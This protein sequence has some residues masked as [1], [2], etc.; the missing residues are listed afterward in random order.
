MRIVIVEDEVLIREG[1]VRL[2]GRLSAAHQVVG[3]AANGRDG[4]AAILSHK[5]DLVITDI[6][7]PDMN[8]LEMLTLA[9]EHGCAC[10]AIVLTAYSEFAYARQAVRLGVI[11]Y[12]LKPIVMDDFIRALRQA[13]QLTRQN[14]GES[15]H[16]LTALHSLRA[17]YRN[18]LDGVR[19]DHDVRAYLHTEY[20]VDADGPFTMALFYGPSPLTDDERNAAHTFKRRLCQTN[21]DCARLLE[22]EEEKW[23][24]VVVAGSG[25]A[26][27]QP[28][29]E[30]LASTRLVAGYAACAGLDA[31]RDLRQRMQARFD[32]AIVTGKRIHAF[33]LLPDNASFSTLAYPTAVETRM[34]AALWARDIAGLE[35]EFNAFFK[36][37]LNP[38]E[39]HAPHEIKECFVRLLWAL[40]SNAK[41]R[42]YPGTETLGRQALLETAMSAVTRGELYAARDMLLNALRV[43]DAAAGVTGEMVSRA[44]TMIHESFATGITLEEIAQKLCITSEYLSQQFHREVGVNYSAYLRALRIGKAKELLRTTDLRIYEVA[45]RVGYP[46][47]K[48]FSRVFKAETGCMPYAYRTAP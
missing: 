45:S 21:G 43:P 29:S 14:Q 42:G 19:V 1:I 38:A 31:L 46:D 26:L 28:L 25:L 18:S 9:H 7:M 27:E 40:L 35:R 33:D 15:V 41:E 34:R 4:L 22:L 2:V 3:E 16:R 10:T 6:R 24:A 32:I 8:G 48:Y 11:E 44:R 37:A 23:L 20:D 13:E 30:A 17:V 47:A 5:P 12:L 39:P 36:V